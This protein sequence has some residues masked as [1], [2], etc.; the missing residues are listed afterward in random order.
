M[1]AHDEDFAHGMAALSVNDRPLPDLP[2]ELTDAIIDQLHDDRKALVNCSV[3]CRRWMKSSRYHLF[4]KVIVRGEKPGSGFTSFL[5]FLD[6]TPV[7]HGYIRSLTFRVTANPTGKAS[8]LR[9]IGPYTLVFILKILPALRT[10]VFENITWNRHLLAGPDGHAI[11]WP[12][13]PRPLDSFTLSHVVTDEPRAF[14]LSNLVDLVWAFG[15]LRR[16]NLINLVVEFDSSTS[17]PQWPDYLHLEEFF[18]Q[19]NYARVGDPSPLAPI[20]EVLSKHLR[21]VDLACGS[22]DEA[23]LVGQLIRFVGPTLQELRL[24]MSDMTVLRAFSTSLMALSP[25]ILII[26]FTFP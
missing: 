2:T 6:A 8:E 18:V 26:T 3:V 9:S 10:L 19:S 5:A 11:D 17:V 13:S 20:S 24:N 21:K 25:F 16:L 15:P 1:P 12:P 14:R 7:I 23:P 4:D 22:D